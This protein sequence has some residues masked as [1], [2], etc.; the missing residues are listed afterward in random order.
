MSSFQP[1][2]AVITGYAY[3][4]ATTAL[5]VLEEGTK[6]KRR[7]SA[8]MMCTL[9]NF[10]KVVLF[11]ERIYFDGCA[12]EEAGRAIPKEA[13]FGASERAKSLFDAED[14]F[15]RISKFEGNRE[16][17]EGRITDALKP[18]DIF[19]DAL[20]VLTCSY[21][22]EPLVIHQEM[23][24]L[25]IFLIE[26]LIENGGI[27]KFKP[28][29]PGEHLY[30]GLRQKRISS[31]LATH[32][33]A[34]LAGNRVRVI[35]REKMQGLNDL[36]SL[37]APP[38]PVLPPIF[39]ARILHDCSTGGD[40]VPTLLKIRNSPAMTRFRKWASKCM[41][42]IA[43]DNVE[44]RAR[45]R[46][47]YD[48]L[49]KFALNDDMSVEDFGKGVLEIVKKSIEGDV[50]GILPDVVS[51]VMKYLGGLPMAV[52]H[53][54]SGKKGGAKHIG[55]FLEKSF[56]D[57]FTQS[58]MDYMST[59]LRLPDNVSVWKTENAEFYTKAG[60]IDPSAPNLA[61]PCFITTGD[62]LDVANAK[63]NF[64]D[65]WGKAEDLDEFLKNK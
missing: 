27:D 41:Q 48:D 31:P 47:A 57:K 23:A 13:V 61:R 11:S 49:T 18:V 59:L 9:D 20:F 34:D 62:V 4:L 30:L 21:N 35:V 5:G 10:V 12:G 46:K 29:F 6:T 14:I 65:L 64:E 56:E 28:V 24:T 8:E 60:R 40:I 38:L 33:I 45:A 54:F 39:V 53:E 52:L 55:T 3:E 37:G 42:Q 58:E 32:S 63:K 19:Q 22:G 15:H 36:A 50:L 43:S 2:D 7:L 17:V 16:L 1:L 25:D 51:P 44:E 26:Y